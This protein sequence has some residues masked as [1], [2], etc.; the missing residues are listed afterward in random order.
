MNKQLIRNQ[1]VTL[2]SSRGLIRAVVVQDLPGIVV[3]CS[4]TEANE[5]KL[6]ARPPMTVGF[7][8]EDVIEV[9]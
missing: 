7:K 6:K 5:A 1:I 4:E 8:K 9:D 3:V 2:N